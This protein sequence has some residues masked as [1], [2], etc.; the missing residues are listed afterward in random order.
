MRHGH[1]SMSGGLSPARGPG[2]IQHARTVNLAR[3]MVFGPAGHCGGS[4][5]PLISG[6][7][8]DSYASEWLPAAKALP[9]LV[10]RHV[11]GTDSHLQPHSA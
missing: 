9:W 1:R 6:P 11:S 3:S 4:A 5:R 2:G 7:F 10:S 8:D